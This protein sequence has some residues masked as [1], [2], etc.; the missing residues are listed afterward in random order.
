[1]S[2]RLGAL[3]GLAALVAAPLALAATPS[4]ARVQASA[5]EFSLALSRQSIRSGSA[6]VQLV[7]Y[8]EDDHDLA[9]RRIAPGARTYRIGIVHPGRTGELSA[10]LRPGRYRLWCTLADHRARGMTATLLVKAPKR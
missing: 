1:M 2:R 10:R 5:D 4:P 6:I 3:T 7:N 9:L 8:G